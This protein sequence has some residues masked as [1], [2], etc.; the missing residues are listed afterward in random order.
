MI[1]IALF[2]L[3]VIEAVKIRDNQKRTKTLEENINNLIVGVSNDLLA[4]FDTLN[5]RNLKLEERVVDLRNHALKLT[6]EV[7]QLQPKAKKG[8]K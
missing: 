5:Y 4:R 7:F 3:V 2:L 1:A 8:K 6:E